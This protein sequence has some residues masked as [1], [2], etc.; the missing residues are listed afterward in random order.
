LKKE[1][2]EEEEIDAEI[3]NDKKKNGKNNMEKIKKE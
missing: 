1:K 3:K 2:Q